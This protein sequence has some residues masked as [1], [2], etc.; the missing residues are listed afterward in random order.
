MGWIFLFVRN[1]L[2]WMDRQS[3]KSLLHVVPDLEH[4]LLD[5]RKVLARG[6]I[7]IGPARRAASSLFLGMVVGMALWTVLGVAFAF[8]AGPPPQNLAQGK[9]RGGALACMLVVVVL[10]AVFSAFR[11]LRGGHMVLSEQGLDMRYR[12]VAVFCPWAVFNTAGQP[13]SPGHGRVVVPVAAL[14]LGMVIARRHGSLLAEGTMVDVPQLRFRSAH[15]AILGALYEVNGAELGKVVLH[16]G[17]I[18]GQ[19]DPGRKTAGAYSD[20]EIHEAEPVAVENGGWITVRITKVQFPAACCDCGAATAARQK[21]RCFE[22]FLGLGRFLNPIG[23]ESVHLWIPVCHACQTINQRR[24][25]QAVWYAQLVVL[26]AIVAGFLLVLVFP[27]QAF[28]GIVFFATVLLAPGLG[29]TIGHRIGQARGVP[30]QLRSYSPEK[31]T[32]AL[33]FRNPQYGERVVEL[34]RMRADA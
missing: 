5:P 27:R 18:L 29:L 23:R 33:R 21:V 28:F 11:L 7:T 20:L 30:V 22:P 16:L 25:R 8:L 2:V 12:G 15:E 24:H 4:L 32:I 9:E 19:T 34:M 6:E 10:L 17:R 31:G 13:Y 26:A 1:A 14:A 3:E